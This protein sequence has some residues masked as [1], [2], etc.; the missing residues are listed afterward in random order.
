[1]ENNNKLYSNLDNNNNVEDKLQYYWNNSNNEEIVTEN[2][3][4][5]ITVNSLK[6]LKPDKWVNDEI[7]NYYSLILKD[8]I[9]KIPQKN[10]ENRIEILSTYFSDKLKLD[11]ENN[12]KEIIKWEK[13]L[14]LDL[15]KL[16][17]LF[18]P[19]NLNN[20]HW[21]LIMVN[22]N[23]KSINY[24][25]SKIGNI[26]EANYYLDLIK[27]WL[28]SGNNNLV[29]VNKLHW[30]LKVMSEEEIP[31]QNN[32]NDCGIFLCY[33]MEKL[34]QNINL[35]DKEV[36]VNKLR[37]EIAL[38]M[39]NDKLE[40]ENKVGK[41]DSNVIINFSNL[42]NRSNPV[43][44]DSLQKLKFTKDPLE[45]I[46]V[47]KE[48]KPKI[49]FS[50]NTLKLLKEHNIINNN[51]ITGLINSNIDKCGDNGNGIIM[52]SINSSNGNGIMESIN[53]NGNGNYLEIQENKEQRH[54]YTFFLEN[55]NYNLQTKLVDIPNDQL[56]GSIMNLNHE[57]IDMINIHNI[58]I[59]RELFIY[60][61]RKIRENINDKVYLE[62]NIKKLILL[63][64][65]LFVYK[66]T[67]KN[68][69]NKWFQI[70]V[71]ELQNDN[72]NNFTFERF[73]F[74]KDK[75][76][77][78]TLE[79]NE[80]IKNNNI[81]K[82][83]GNGNISKAASLLEQNF[84]DLSKLSN[85]Q[86]EYKIKN[87][88]KILK[89]K[90]PGNNNLNLN[91]A[92]NDVFRDLPNL[93]FS[94]NEVMEGIKK[95]KKNIASGPGNL[96]YDLLKLLIALNVKVESDDIINIRQ[97]IT[98]FM[99][100]LGSNKI[101]KSSMNLFTDNIIIKIP[102]NEHSDDIRP[103][104]LINTWRKLFEICASKM[105][106]KD[107]L[108]KKLVGQYCLKQHAA[109]MMINNINKVIK[110]NEEFDKDLI[111]LD[112]KNAFGLLNIDNV[113]LEIK[114]KVPQLFIPANNFL[115][116]GNGYTVGAVGEKNC[117]SEIKRNKGLIQGSPL[118]PLFYA[119][120]IQ[121][122]LDTLYSEMNNKEINP[123]SSGNNELFCYMDD[124]NIWMDY[125]LVNNIFQILNNKGKEIGYEINFEKTWILLGKSRSYNEALMKIEN[126]KKFGINEESIKIH[127][128][129]LQEAFNNNIISKE[130]YIGGINSYGKKIVGGYIG[131]SQFIESELND[132][133]VQL[134][135]IADNILKISNLQ[136]R[137]T[138]FLKS[139][140]TK[141][142]HILRHTSPSLTQN[143]TR[144]FELLKDRIFES[145][146]MEPNID[147]KLKER[148]Q[149]QI[150]L[151]ISNGGF[152]LSDTTYIKH[153]AYIA[154]FLDSNNEEEKF[155]IEKKLTTKSNNNIESEHFTKLE[156]ELLYSMDKLSN[157]YNEKV[158]M[159]Y[160]LQL[161]SM[162]IDEKNNIFEIENKSKN[163]K[164][165]TDKFHLYYKN[166]FMKYLEVEK[167]NKF[168]AWFISIN[169]N[170]A[171]AWIN[172]IPKNNNIESNIFNEAFSIIIKKW[173]HCPISSIKGL[174]CKCGNGNKFVDD[175]GIHILNSC[176]YGGVRIDLHDTILNLLYKFLQINDE[177]VHKEQSYDIPDYFKDQDTKKNLRK[178]KRC[179][180]MWKSKINAEVKLIDI[181]QTQ[182]YSP[183]SANEL[184]FNQ[185]NKEERAMEK[186][187]AAKISKYDKRP[188]LYDA[189]LIVCGMENSGRFNKDF[190]NL[191]NSTIDKNFPSMFNKS[192]SK[193]AA[194]LKEYWCTRFSWCFQKTNAINLLN[195]ASK[196]RLSHQ[197]K[198]D[199]ANFNNEE[200]F[201]G[202]IDKHNPDYILD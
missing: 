120:G 53:S 119:L 37:K 184:S 28:L 147:K 11:K 56:I 122:L 23:N 98:E 27:E 12:T 171:S 140:Q 30:N 135:K 72:W 185:A 83:V 146:I 183:D 93:K 197:I 178:G 160:L 44:L 156:S 57:S 6:K 59:I 84:V 18:I 103:I 63:P 46:T 99:N 161:K 179:D 2:N 148:I 143:L 198:Y 21:T 69:R 31:Q 1:M 52:E 73:G 139:F 66:P 167:N 157:F 91:N 19:I 106:N 155:N 192:E 60:Y 162:K 62:L 144:E 195:Q 105:Y 121:N 35:L 38:L 137:W 200:Y 129:N 149:L 20:I 124:L 51:G 24:Y 40:I 41:L 92:N 182:V 164:I 9:N 168:L 43:I 142:N 136:V 25:D 180:I 64:T 115:S 61:L 172:N 131:T 186:M 49:I 113:L 173:I 118:S 96:S 199:E 177:I 80:K 54:N 170:Y 71:I 97:E 110:K 65:I 123:L 151:R 104:G 67:S 89:E 153:I 159:N 36:N 107:E 191:I 165:L 188:R 78:I 34:S 141:I 88:I 55:T 174:R 196:L 109:D 175:C 202:Y 102:K 94:L 201:Q 112:A 70:R 17:K 100:M 150:R 75:R 166:E 127:P 39:V 33:Y 10:E 77:D 22:F 4:V 152:G 181:C 193:S 7:I 163:Q 108:N 169:D 29:K 68:Q 48:K 42:I 158:D 116:K 95:S 85:V 126:Y 13:K 101:P 79:L 194:I 16:D 87:Q 82:S 117:I 86:L 125:D 58:K 154:S 3:G 74:R 176:G 45:I 14:N 138:I 26:I 81:I 114:Q 90:F 189:K 133:I 128:D 111:I 15:N 187:T 50:K 190:K 130:I 145:F 47:K 132:K 134:K 8:S 5:L 76:Y 32:N